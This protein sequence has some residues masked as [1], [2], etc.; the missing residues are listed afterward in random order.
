MCACEQFGDCARIE[1]WLIV[2]KPTQDC[3]QFLVQ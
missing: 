2:G 1:N 3:N